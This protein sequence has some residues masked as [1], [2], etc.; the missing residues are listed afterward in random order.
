MIHVS[1][2]ETNRK[3]LEALGDYVTRA[4]VDWFAV[5][6][7]KLAE[8]EQ[9]AA[10]NNRESHLIVY[11]T[12]AGDESDHYVIPISILPKLLTTNAL[13]HSKVNGTTRWNVTLNDHILRVSHND[14][15]VDASP[16]YKLPLPIEVSNRTSAVSSNATDLEPPATR[17]ASTVYRILRDTELAKQLKRDYQYCCQVCG[18]TIVLPDGSRYA[19]AHH[20]RPLGLPHR[21][22]DR[23]ENLIVLC[24]NHH[25]MCDY[26]AMKL[27][28]DNLRIIDGH[29]IDSKYIAYHNECVCPKPVDI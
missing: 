8:F 15:N 19:E 3:Q 10:R 23:V 26:G 28:L 21:G 2:V 12:R 29:K 20:I 18:H 14:H 11:R 7:Q 27:V 9:I 1:V 6:P 5:F 22:P 13:T 4:N 17:I 16:Y 25:A 24:P